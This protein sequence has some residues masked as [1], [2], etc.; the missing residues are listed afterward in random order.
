M[1]NIIIFGGGKIGYA[2]A[3]YIR[4]WQLFEIA[5]HVV[6][7]Q[8]VDMNP[9]GLEVVSSDKV[10][11][12]FP[13]Q[14]YSAFVALGY[15][16]LNIFRA[17][18][19]LQLASLGYDLV[20]VVNPDAP[21]D[22]KVGGNCFVAAGE[23][24]QPGCKV[25]RNGFVWNGATIGHNCV[26]GEDAWITG[27]AS[28]GGNV[29]VGRA[30]FVGIGATIGNGVVIG[31]N[32]VLGAG[33]LCVKDIADNVVLVEKETPTFRLNSEQFKKMSGMFRG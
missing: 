32:C 11:D 30:S 33:A 26:V 8:Y 21:S 5:T 18:K 13:P 2:V 22:L 6:D 29:K 7:E 25:E 24:I 19:C 1:K 4:Q 3:H 17:E 9:M 16:D 10:L 27:G 28:I 15:H 20:D 31:R 14:K 12:R 23:T